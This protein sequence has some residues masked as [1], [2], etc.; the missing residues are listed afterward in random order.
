M[1]IESR[2][3]FWCLV[4]RY[5]NRGIARTDT[6]SQLWGKGSRFREAL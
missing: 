5:A 3:V 2:L 4:G 1:K 6:V